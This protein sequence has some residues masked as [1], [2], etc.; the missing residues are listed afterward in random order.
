MQGGRDREN[1]DK[2]LITTTSKNATKIRTTAATMI[3]TS[4]RK[5]RGKNTYGC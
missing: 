5:R 4:R 1:D 2:S 3:K